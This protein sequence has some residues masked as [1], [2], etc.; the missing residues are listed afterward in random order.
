MGRLIKSHFKCDAQ[1][2][3]PREL[4]HFLPALPWS[5]DE[6]VQRRKCCGGREEWQVGAALDSQQ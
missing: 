2:R 5:I 6:W 4:L 1:S 3:G